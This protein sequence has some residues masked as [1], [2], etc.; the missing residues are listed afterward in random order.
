MSAPHRRN[1]R[2]RVLGVA[3]ALVATAALV[4]PPAADASG[5]FAPSSGSRIERACNRVPTAR[6]RVLHKIDLL[7]AGATTKGSIA[8]LRAKADKAAAKG[9]AATAEVLRAKA[10][11]REA[12]LV[13]LRTKLAALDKAA[14][15]CAA[16]TA[17]P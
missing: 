4:A 16:R 15:A 9:K 3:A 10:T 13:A 11:A 7:E 8:W 5:R 17:T 6:D 14:A 1:I 2:N 12:A